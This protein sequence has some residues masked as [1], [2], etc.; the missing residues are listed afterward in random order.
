MNE[1]LVWDASYAIAKALQASH[2]DV[3]ME[4]VSLRAIYQWTLAL[5][6]FDDDPE[7]ANDEI[8]TAIYLDWLEEI[9]ET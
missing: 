9:L 7:L 4:E 3:D 8:L 6:A 5:P 1:P 2:P